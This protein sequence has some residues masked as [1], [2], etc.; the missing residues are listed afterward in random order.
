MP[1]LF[2]ALTTALFFCGIASN[3]LF[4]PSLVMD[5]AKV[6]LDNYCFPENLVGMQETIEQAVKGG[7]I[8][9]ISDPDTLANVFTSGVQGYLNDPRLVVSYEP[10]YSGPQTEQSLELTPEQLKFLINHSVKYDILPGN[11][12]YLRIDFI[13]GQDVV[14]KVGP[15][16]VNNIWKKLMPTSALIL[17]LRYSTQGEVSGIPFVVSYLCDSEIHIDS[18]YN[19]PSN[20]TTDLW[21]LPELMGERYGKVKDVVVLTS[22]Y[23]KGVAEDA[24]YILKHMNRAIVVGEKTAGGSLDTQKIKIGQSDFYITVPVSRSLSPLTGQSWEVS[25]VSPCVV[26]NAKDALDK[27]QAILAVRS[28]VTH[29]LHQLCDILANNYAFSERIP[30]LLQHLPNLDYS[31][32]I[33]E[34]DIAAKLNYELQSL[35]EDPRLVLKSKTDTLVMPGDSIQAENI[36]EDEAML[37]ALVNTVFKVSILPGN[38]GYLRFD[39]F[40]DVS[41]IAKLAPFIVNTVWEPITITENLI[42]DLRYNVGGSSTAVPLLLSYFLDPETKIHL[43]TLHNRQQNSTDEV[44]SHPKV[45]GKPYGSKKGVYV[46]TSHQT[47]TA[48]EE[49]AYLMQSLSRATIIG[50]I[51]SGN[52]MHSKVFPF[53]GTQLSVTVPII[54]FIDSNGDYW[55]GGGV[56]PD[57]IVLADEALDKAKEIIAFHPSIFPLVKGTGHLLEV[58]YAIP[59][60]AYKVSSVL[61]NKWSE[62]GYRS[63]VDLESLASLLT[64][65]MQE[66]SGDHRLHVFYSDTEPEILEDQPPKI[67][68]PEELNYI[69]DALFKIEVLPGNVGYLRFDMMADTEIIK[70]IG[71]QLVSLV[72]NKLVET[73]SLIIDMR[74]NT[75]GYSTAIPI[76]CSYFFD[77]EPLQHLY[78]VY[79]RSTSTGK[80]I[81]TLPEVFGERY[82]STKDIYILTSH[83]TGSAAE[84]FTRSLKDLNRATLIG[85]PTS[86]VSLSV[87]MYKVGDSNLYVTI[88]NQVVISSV[89]GKVW[90]VSGVEPHVIIQ[91]NEAMNIAHR[92]I[93]LRTKIPTVIQTAAKLVADNYAFA[94]TGANVAS[95]FIALV[96]KIDY[97]MI[98]SEVELAEKINDDLQSLSKDFHLKAVY[99]PEN[100][101]DRIPGVVPM[102]I[103]SPE[104]FEE[105]IKFS[106]HTDVFEKN[107]GYIRFDMFADSDL[108]NQV[109]DLLVEHVWKKVVDQD[110]LIIDMRFNI[111]GPT[112]SIPIFCS[113]FFDEGTPVLLDKIY[114]R[115]SNAMTDIWTLPDLVGKTFGSKKP[116]IILTSSLTEGAAEEFVYIMKRLGRAYV[117]GEVTSGGCHPP[118]TYHVDDTHLYLTIPTSRSASA[119]PGESWEGKGVLPDLEI[120]SETA[121]LKAKEILESQLEGRR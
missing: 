107:I 34:E 59:E 73:N 117:V 54:N 58:H 47:A 27:A 13:I 15:H 99:I 29:V 101:K 14:Q 43:F 51:T 11:I 49:F 31:T 76:F 109:S 48:A 22:K 75:G 104:L 69:I 79:D 30:T 65:E 96:D 81:W 53:D 120:S 91:A 40:A 6:L 41:V 88:P 115:T 7:E 98:K 111:G 26:V 116:L 19:R 61:Q 103:P 50:E 35:T 66:N 90:S 17:D 114:S 32:V 21:T 63:V 55:L 64:S 33:S 18:I 24:S 56:V 23:T 9:H 8:L 92:I 10:N 100:S 25:G 95:K 87:G 68:S 37:Q 4:Q 84:V 106:F 62:G 93:K 89:T 57:A 108:L 97:K 80:D 72:W 118:Q 112:S 102:Q 28:S 121:L 71:P 94:D 82:G 46:L 16:L 119:E 5:M 38:I 60:V 67:P 2:Q 74:Y 44:Y 85:E 83:M 78:T 113:Y 45:L 20:T 77:P 52:L 110:A 70:A 12:G 1:P 39:Q 86:G 3:P 36:P 105:L 42:I